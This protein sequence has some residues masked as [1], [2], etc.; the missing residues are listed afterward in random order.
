MEMFCV[1]IMY[2]MSILAVTESQ[3]DSL[4]RTT[5]DWASFKAG[6]L[7]PGLD[8][9][10]ALVGDANWESWQ[11]WRTGSPLPSGYQQSQRPNEQERWTDVSSSVHIR[12]IGWLSEEHSNLSTTIQYNLAWVDP[13][14]GGLAASWFPI[15]ADL[16]WTP[17]IS[18]GRNVRRTSVVD[19]GS[20]SDSGISMWLHRSGIMLYSI[21]R[22][23]KLT[24]SV[25]LWRYP[26]D[27]Q[28]C[29][30]KLHGYNGVMFNVLT[31]NTSLQAP[32]TTDATAVRS[33]Y[34]LKAVEIRLERSSF[35][36]ER[37]SC[38]YFSQKC[39]HDVEHCLNVASCRDDQVCQ[40][41]KSSVG[42]C[43]HRVNSCDDQN[44]SND[45]TTLEVR[46]HL[47]RR[48]LSYFFTTFI[49]CTVVVISSFLQTWLP[50]VPSA[51]AGRFVL[52]IFAVLV[53]ISGHNMRH[54]ILR[55]S[56]ARAIDIWI[57]ACI[58][59]VT[60]AL[61]QTVVL[62]F[63]YD[64]LKRKEKKASLERTP[65]FHIPR[66]HLNRPLSSWWYRLPNKQWMTM[67][68]PY[69]PSSSGAVGVDMSA[70][71]E[72]TTKSK[73]KPL[74]NIPRAKFRQPS[75]ASWEQLPSNQWKVQ[76]NYGSRANT[77][78]LYEKDRLPRSEEM[79]RK[80]DRASRIAFPC[81]FL[82]FNLWFWLFY[83]LF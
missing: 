64:R 70:Y 26:F 45:Y 80:I 60:L 22:T 56:E 43:S 53:M 7:H 27:S 51:I 15:P 2:V 34:M 59:F 14:L 16:A 65:S 40:Q 31:S 35:L 52:G 32:I 6:S 49:P 72:K 30:V 73:V 55:V 8:G 10:D 25:Q 20:K 48:L 38:E 5:Q 28:V 68:N 21:T 69:I 44:D 3:L 57:M 33:Q 19:Q 47:K 81:A 41:C 78:E 75:L 54:L 62:H 9:S 82:V 66:P 29:S 36:N 71:E 61:L 79:T 76:L 63:V 12:N 24:C 18:F 50:L 39:D 42:R 74:V 13:R 4:G 77:G 67:Y 58:L 17:P 46:I 1:H 11:V 37:P 83:L 23:L